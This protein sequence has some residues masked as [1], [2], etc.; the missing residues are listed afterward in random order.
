MT[1]ESQPNTADTQPA[2]LE[3]EAEVPMTLGPNGPAMSAIAAAAFSI[4]ALGLLTT[5]SEAAIGV[6]DWLIFQNR[7]GPLSGKTTMAG[8]SWLATWA[9]LH[10]V[11]RNR[12]CRSSRWSSS[13]RSSL[14]SAT[15]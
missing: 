6:H 3:A 11:W 1:A 14:S 5:L 8:V 10:L 15:C 9:P 12:E 2:G 4:F 13:L 7:V